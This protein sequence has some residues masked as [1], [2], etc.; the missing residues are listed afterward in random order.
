MLFYEGN[1]SDQVR[2]VC[3]FDMGGVSG[4]VYL[5]QRRCN[6]TWTK[7]HARLNGLDDLPGSNKYG[8]CVTEYPANI[9]EANP[10]SPA[11][12]G[13][14][15]NPE[16]IDTTLSTYPAR[17]RADHKQCAIGDLATRHNN[18][19]GNDSGVL[20][21]YRDF[22]LNLYG[23]NTVVGRALTLKRLDTNAAVSCCNIKIP[24]NA[25]VLRAPFA[26]KAFR[27][28]IK[29]TQP[30]YDYLN[31]TKNEN[32]IIMVDLER[33]NGG[34]A[35][36]PN[37]GWQLRRGVADDTCSRVD[38]DILGY[39]PVLSGVT[40]SQTQHR[41]CRLGDLTTKCGPLQLVNNR[42]RAQCT[43]NQ[44]G[45][46]SFS[47]L[48]KLAVTITNGNTIVDCAQ[49][50]EVL[51]AGAYVNFR[52]NGGHANMVFSQLSPFD[53]TMYRNYVV[54]LNGEAGNIVVYDGPDCSNLG[55]VLD[56]PGNLPIANPKTGDQYPIGELGPKMGGVSGKNYLRNQ[57][58]SSN[59]PLTGSVNILNKP[60]TVL[61]E[62][63]SV[64]GCG[65]VD[66]YYNAPYQPPTDVI[67][68]LDLFRP[69]SP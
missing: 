4:N 33:I 65:T 64:W 36:I 24:T 52:F 1:H 59:I 9:N 61:Y 16:G 54:G 8:F 2:A 23:P 12:V 34:Q 43:D 68:Y 3:H 69:P 10:C 5:L 20:V 49:L 37:L 35:S 28:E 19:T 21:E 53:P 22:N 39:P 38:P 13:G 26:G 63:G 27:G 56:R 51:P 7:I 32:T 60:I 6:S 29:I 58:L 17:C 31:Y 30:S 44:L 25:R 42:I 18:L 66:N 41:T 46:V 55:N 15:Y 48:D 47:T 14:T 50:G 40:C 57:G 67:D 45:L 62:N 11:V